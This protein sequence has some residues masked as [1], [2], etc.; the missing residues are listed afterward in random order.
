[1]KNIKKIFGVVL[2]LLLA[3]SVFACGKNNKLTDAESVA[4][5]KKSLSTVA[6]SNSW[7]IA[8]VAAIA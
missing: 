1:M 5:A 6:L 2:T 7:S 3:V 4:G 8:A